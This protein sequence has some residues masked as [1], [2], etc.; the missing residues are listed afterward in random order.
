MKIHM[1]LPGLVTAAL[2]LAA[3]STGSPIFLT[4]G[5]LTALLCA[6]SAAG[7]YLAGRSLQVRTK[8]SDARVQRGEDVYLEIELACRSWI[9]V[10]PLQVELTESPDRPEQTLRMD[11]R[12]GR[13]LRLTLPLHAAHVGVY[14]PGVRAVTITDLFGLCSMTCDT[15]LEP[16]SLMV[17][18]VPFDVDDLTYTAGE[19]ESEAMARATEDI[20]SPADVRAY[21][22]GDSM[23]KIHWK[24]S[25]RKGELL[26]RRF[27]APVMPD[28][29]VLM[30]CS[31]PPRQSSDEA[32]ADLRD[33]LLETAA[34]IL[35]HSVRTGHPARL[36]VYGEHPIELDRG[37]GMPMILE[38]LARVDFTASDRFE[39]VLQLELRRMR[40]V[41]CTVVIAARLNSRMVDVMISMRRMGPSLRFCL[42]SRDPENPALLP[43]IARLQQAAVE[44]SFLTLDAPGN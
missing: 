24:L 44:V 35:Q 43:M 2:L 19:S 7:V 1:M 4:G 40:K 31:P 39:R 20:N 32:A 22:H 28:A 23:K 38:S 42:I 33:A 6:G 13:P 17:L 5:L 37:M 21:Q 11:V 10:A 14:S 8:L 12:P 36:P 25:L 27:E 18:P 30:D 15:G 41:G 9:P 29:L 16:D 3:F 34:S 26:V